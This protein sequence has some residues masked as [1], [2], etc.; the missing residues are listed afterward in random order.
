MYFLSL[1][2][3]TQ[4]AAE[5]DAAWNMAV[6]NLIEVTQTRSVYGQVMNKRSAAGA[7]SSDTND[8]TEPLVG[9]AVVLAIYKDSLGT[10]RCENTPILGF[11]MKNDRLP[12]QARDKH[13]GNSTSGVF[14][15]REATMKWVVELLYPTLLQWNQWAWRLRR[16]NVGADAPH[17]GLLVLGADNGHLP[18]EG[19]T[20]TSPAHCSGKAFGALA[21]VLE[22]GMDNSP[23]YDNTFDQ[24][25]ATYNATTVR[26]KGGFVE[27]FVVFVP[28]L[29]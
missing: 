12:R 14:P 1:M 21:A 19:G 15:R 11:A 13:T 22:S 2:A 5:D 4:P 24:Q 17:G 18:C 27:V 9:S 29:S 23:M 28:S 7:K 6:S 26:K 16:Y 3:G 25:P 8:R 20:V 10:K